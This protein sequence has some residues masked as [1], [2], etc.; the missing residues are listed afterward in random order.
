MSIPLSD[1]LTVHNSDLPKRIPNAFDRLDHWTSL[2]LVMIY[3]TGRGE[4]SKWGPYLQLLPTEFDTLM[5]WTQAELA[6]LQGSLVIDKIGKDDANRLFIETLLPVVQDHAC[7]FGT[8][9]SAFLGVNAKSALL[10]LAH[11]MA[12]LIMA[13]AFDIAHDDDSDEDSLDD[14][15]TPADLPKAMI[16][17][18]DIFNAEGEKMNVSHRDLFIER[19]LTYQAYLVRQDDSMSMI[20][21]KAIRK[22]QEIFNDYG[23]R[24]RSDLLRRYGYITDSAKKWDVVELNRTAVI[25]IASDHHKLSSRERN[26]RVRLVTQNQ[27]AW[28]IS[29]AID[30]S[31]YWMIGTT[32][33][34]AMNSI[35]RRMVRSLDSNLR[36]RA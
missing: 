2:V 34:I 5:Y 6:E 18:A 33:R 21:S 4:D 31:N 3:E 1:L 9:T 22:G 36:L 23:E 19:S 35:A 27:F 29:N 20:A 10:E 15:S 14:S 28:S 26:Q 32:V 25:Q 30:S 13:Y 8:F 12:S 16:P 11:R 24:P 7:L 17:L